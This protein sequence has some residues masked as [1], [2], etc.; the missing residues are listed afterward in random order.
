MQIR[1]P[2]LP[3]GLLILSFF[4]VG[5]GCERSNQS[6]QAARETTGDQGGAV[7][8]SASEKA[9]IK[10]AED[11]EIDERNLGR[12]VIERSDNDEV[13]N[14]AKSIVNEDTKTL[15]ELVALMEKDQ[16]RQP[17]GMPEVKHE[18]LAE[19]SGLSGPALDREFTNLMV[20]ELQKSVDMYR[21][22]QGTMQH[23]A[24]RDYATD[25]LPFLEK[26]LQEA[27]QLQQKLGRH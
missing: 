16:M 18:A 8:L 23:G 3:M 11:A 24:V 20:Q 12:E 6:V 5:F 13:K 21:V 19:L 2:F 1:N 10:A 27:Q 9:F 7:T 25:R 26:H 14:F 4:L 15:S 22:A 17:S